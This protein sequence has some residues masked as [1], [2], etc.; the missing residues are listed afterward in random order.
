VKILKLTFVNANSILMIGE[1]CWPLLTRFIRLN[2]RLPPHPF[3]LSPPWSIPSIIFSHFQSRPSCSG[4]R[5]LFPS[6]VSQCCVPVYFHPFVPNHHMTLPSSIVSLLVIPVLIF[7]H[8]S[9]P[10]ASVRILLLT[11]T[12]T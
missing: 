10:N 7:S 2:I 4:P 9:S 3:P 5:P 1:W 8:H 12:M 11:T 6:C